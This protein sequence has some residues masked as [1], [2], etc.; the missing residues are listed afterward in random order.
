MEEVCRLFASLYERPAPY[1]ELLEEF[2][3]AAKKR[4]YVGSLSGGQR[5][6]LSI[7]LALLP[8]PELVFLDELTTGL[9]PQARRIMWAHIREL[10]GRGVTVFLTTHYMEE[11][12]SLCDRICLINRG[13][14][15][16]LDTVPGVIEQSGLGQGIMFESDQPLPDGLAAALPQG[17]RIERRGA[18]YEIGGQGEALLG[19]VGAWLENT[20]INYRNLRIRRP[21]LEDAFLKLTGVSIRG[22]LA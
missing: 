1:G 5:Q 22:D 18:L 14:I 20:G 2:G 3:L 17:A 4:A 13:C 8:R 10:K 7:L 6:K 16:A 9:D 12:E 11:A 21:T 15:A 19:K